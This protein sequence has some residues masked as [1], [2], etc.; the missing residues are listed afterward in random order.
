MSDHAVPVQPKVPLHMW[1]LGSL[2]SPVFPSTASQALQASTIAALRM[3]L[4]A[5]V[6]DSYLSQLMQCGYS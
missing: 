4:L 6:E 3:P 5:T 2:L 1:N